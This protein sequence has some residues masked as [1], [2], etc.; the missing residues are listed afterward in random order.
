MLAVLVAPA[1]LAACSREAITMPQD[2]MDER[3]L[4]DVRAAETRGDTRPLPV[5]I[6]L[7]GAGDDAR[8]DLAA[9]DQRLAAAIARLGSALETHGRRP[10]MKSM[11][12]SNAIATELTREEMDVVAADPAVTRLV[13][14]RA[15]RVTIGDPPV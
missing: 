15:D 11:A 3:L 1:G 5:L 10:A 14:N 8:P 9:R 2:K 12:L 7:V 4:A 13:S 6:V